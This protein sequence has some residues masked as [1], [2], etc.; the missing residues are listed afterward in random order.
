ME[1]KVKIGIDAQRCTC[2]SWIA[3][4]RGRCGNPHCV[5]FRD[6]PPLQLAIQGVCHESQS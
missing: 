5:N 3:D 2:G 6:T 4:D 1:V